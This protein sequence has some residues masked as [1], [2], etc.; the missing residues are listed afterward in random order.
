MWQVIDC[1]QAFEDLEDRDNQY[2][3][4]V[5]TYLVNGDQMSTLPRG[6][7][8]DAQV[9]L[10]FVRLRHL[11]VVILSPVEVQHLL[12]GG[13]V[14]LDLVGYRNCWHYPDSSPSAWLAFSNL[15][16]GRRF[17]HIENTGSTSGY[18]L[19][20]LAVAILLLEQFH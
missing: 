1:Q 2:V 14:H 10:A 13:N 4:K 20:H 15:F 17:Y 6:R 8:L 16:H 19:H 7:L 9:I 3:V 11:N 18:N 5:G 12:Q